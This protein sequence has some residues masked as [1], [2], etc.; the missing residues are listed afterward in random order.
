M[1]REAEFHD[2]WAENIDIS[3]LDVRRAFESPLAFEN[4]FILKKLGSLAGKRI[5]DVG[6]GYG[7]SSVYFALKGA[8]V[9]AL[10]PSPMM[11]K[12]MVA[13]A[14]RHRVQV[15]SVVGDVHDLPDPPD[16]Y[17]IVYLGNVIHHVEDRSALFARIRT[18]LKPGGVFVSMDPLTYNPVIRI[19][20]RMAQ[21]VRTVDERPLTTQDIALARRYF[22]KVSHR[23]FWLL[24]LAL[25]LKYYLLDRVDP[26][27]ERYWKKILD[28]SWDTIRWMK[29]LL[30]LD[31]GLTRI[32]GLRLLCWNIVMWGER[33]E[34]LAQTENGRIV[35]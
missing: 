3:S 23:E 26:N 31:R 35:G 18:L 11:I 22:N 29:P 24:S 21:Q 10:D 19:Y 34:G 30:W 12:Q 28:E 13:L 32:P 16:S 15:H 5:L 27:Q 8:K 4:R 20:R 6:A 2:R 33:T 17:D 7:E 1:S 9:T 14:D 25:F